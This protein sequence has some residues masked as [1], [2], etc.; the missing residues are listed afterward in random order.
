MLSGSHLSRC[1]GRQISKTN[2]GHLNV[3]GWE[4]TIG[5]RDQLKTSLI[6]LISISEILKSKLE[7]LTEQT[8]ME[9]E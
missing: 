9:Q 2:S 5:W 3:K 1:T 6:M 4:F 8:D 7:E